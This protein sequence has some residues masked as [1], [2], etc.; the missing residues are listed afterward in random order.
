MSLN[1]QQTHA[2]SRRSILG[3]Q[4]YAAQHNGAVAVDLKPRT[5]TLQ[6]N[7]PAGLRAAECRNRVLCICAYAH[8]QQG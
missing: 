1:A 2:A 5:R 4:A 8:R 6:Q 7:K 3:S